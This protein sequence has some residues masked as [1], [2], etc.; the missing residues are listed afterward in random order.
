LSVIVLDCPTGVTPVS[1]LQPIMSIAS[2]VQLGAEG[3]MPITSAVG[4]IE[5]DF[6]TR[7]SAQK[8]GGP[9]PGHRYLRRS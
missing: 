7:A 9:G 2:V 3:A 5:A 8:N 4:W 1:L 6:W